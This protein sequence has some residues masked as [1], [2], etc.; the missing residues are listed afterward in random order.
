MNAASPSVLAFDT[1]QAWC[2]ACILSDGLPQPL[3]R[4]DE[5]SRGQAEHLMPMLE[6]MLAE[7][8]LAW[9]ELGLIGVGTGPGNF[10]GIRISVAAARGLA[11]SLDRP[12]IGVSAFESAAMGQALP[13]W[14][15]VDAPRGQVYLQRLGAGRASPPELADLARL[16]QLDA[17]LV[18][19]SDITPQQ[20]IENIARQ[21]LLSKD[22][23]AGRAAPLYVRAPDAAPPRDPAP[24]ILP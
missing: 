22:Q 10:T 21:A 15:A 13:L 11:M 23:P 5:M 6:E 14:V 2:A 17:P 3:V 1:S 18:R 16:Q 9:G 8:G 4:I 12:A 7:A 20:R 24:V 19:A